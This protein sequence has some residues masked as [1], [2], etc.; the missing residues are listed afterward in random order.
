MSQWI[1]LGCLLCFSLIVFALLKFIGS[2][3]PSSLTPYLVLLVLS[4]K[5]IKRLYSSHPNKRN[6]QI[7][8][9]FGS[10]EKQTFSYSAFRWSTNS[11]ESPILES[12]Q[13][14][15]HIELQAQEFEE[16]NSEVCY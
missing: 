2:T 9:G 13:L 12:H 6:F 4:Y 16:V 1:Y 7:V 14:S 11:D 3:L 10:M 8:S 15:C 5:T